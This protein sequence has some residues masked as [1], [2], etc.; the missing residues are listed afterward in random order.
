MKIGI[1][2]AGITGLAAAYE[3]S[4]KGHSVEVFEAQKV[5]GGLGTYIPV[6]NSYI[7]R[8]Y[9]HFFQ[10][11]T[12]IQQY[13]DELGVSDK[14][15]YYTS[16]NGVY[17]NGTIH[18]FT[19]PMD[20]LNFAPL[21]MIER[22]R[23]AATLSLFKILPVPLRFLDKISAA[24]WIKKYAGENVYKKLWGPLL[25]GKF[26][27]YAENVPALWLWGRI[28]D[29]SMKLGY[30]DGSVKILFDELVEA[31]EKNDGKVHLGAKVTGVQKKGN[32]IVLEQGRK[33]ILFDNLITTTVSP[34][35]E[36][37][38]QSRLPK[39]YRNKLSNKD[40]LGAVCLV[41]VLKNRVQDNYWV[42]ICEDDADVLVMV[43]HTNF[44]S[45]NDYDSKHI[46]YL[47][48]YLHRDSDEFKISED[49][50]LKKYTRILKKMNPSFKKSWITESHISKVPRAQTIFSLGALDELPDIET[51]VKGIYMV[52]IDQ[53]YPHDRNLNQGIS[54][55]QKV[56]ERIHAEG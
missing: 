45:E 9:H 49:E 4:K 24:S 2:G 18:P 33:K 44:V 14:L 27:S 8:Y 51:P 1:I 31:I 53:M 48:N 12:L 21:T 50:I 43:E 41:L 13:A 37:I 19:S 36:K 3:L 28:F 7:E 5:P 25:K 23:C 46:V 55:G 22:F 38:I 10:S 30:F 47:A 26:S 29:R 39:K 6:A 20:L 40:H 52:N 34:I 15:H 42:N 17:E 35:T 11:D 56:A 54:L 32:K 16:K